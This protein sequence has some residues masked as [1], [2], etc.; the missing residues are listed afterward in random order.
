MKKRLPKIQRSSIVLWVII[1]FMLILVAV[2][3]SLRREEVELDAPAE[4]AY[5]VHTV[6]VEARTVSDMV[7][8]PGRVEPDLRAQLAV[9]KGGRITE[10]LADK[11]DRVS[12][13]DVLLRID[14]RVWRAAHDQAEIELREAERDYRRWTEL[15]RTGSVSTSE[16][17]AVRA[18]Y[19][20]AR[21][22]LQDAQVHVDQCVVRSPADGFINRRM[23]EVGEYAAEGVAV[24]ELVVSD[25]VRLA[26]DV[27]ERDISAVG[28]GDA[29]PFTISILGESDF[30]GT[31]ANIAEAASPINNSYRIEA[32]VPNSDRVLRPGML[33]EARLQRGRREGAVVVPLSAVLPRRGDHFV[34]VA[35]GESAVRRLVR[36]ERILGAEAILA[37]GLEPGDELIWEGH[38]E[39]VDGALIERVDTDDEPPAEVQIDPSMGTEAISEHTHLGF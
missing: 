18:R 31:V 22:Q 36:L 23:I 8:L 33:A 29:I 14:D 35:Q 4:R 2:S 20:R 39:L 9:D 15:S 28:V 37:S 26:I 38:R 3:M 13:G 25:P 21:V 32:T 12:K 1:I 16:F 6:I 19:D 11:G 7:R 34:F 10:L 24:F 5:P 27:P 30:E 17:D